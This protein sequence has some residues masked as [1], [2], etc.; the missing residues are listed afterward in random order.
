[1]LNIFYIIEHHAQTDNFRVIHNPILSVK[2]PLNSGSPFIIK[3]INFFEI[4]CFNIEESK[5]KEEKKYI[6]RYDS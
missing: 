2:F 3:L 4:K 1:M 5:F 6:F